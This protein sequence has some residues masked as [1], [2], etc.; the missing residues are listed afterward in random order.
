MTHRPAFPAPVTRLPGAAAREAVHITFE[1]LGKVYPG[2]SSAALQ[3]VSLAVQRGERFGIIGRSGAGK[4]T[5]LRT[6]NALELPSTGQVKVDGVDVAA[7]GEEALVDLR[8][9]IGMIFQHFNLLSAKTV[10]ENVALPLRVAG[11]PKAQIAPRV[12]ELLALVGLAGRAHAYPAMLSGGQKQ[13]VGIARAL[14][15]RPEILLCD[16]ATSAL[17]PET[18]DAI[19]ALLGD[20]QREFGLTV[21]L[22]THDMAVIHQACERVLVLEQGRIAELG[23]VAEVFA[24][25]LSAATRALLRPL[26]HAWQGRPAYTGVRAAAHG[27]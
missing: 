7:L 15:H 20:V 1:G 25:P 13:R 10:F 14:V 27:S 16:E 22:I 2:A 5:L 23:P 21:V 11:V 9:R 3:D 17:D 4:S 24:N 19:L 8:R 18:T 12:N 6:I 26:Q